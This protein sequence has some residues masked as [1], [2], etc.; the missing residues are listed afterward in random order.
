LAAGCPVLFG[1]HTE[2]FPDLYAAMAE[3]GAARCVATA[4]LWTHVQRIANS[5]AQADGPHAS[6]QVAGLAFIA[7]QQGSA[8]RTLAQLATLPCWPVEPMPAIRVQREGPHA[9]WTYARTAEAL[10]HALDARAFDLTNHAQD[11]HNLATGSG[12]GQAHKVQHDGHTWVLRHYRRGGWVARW[13]HDTYPSGPTVDTRAM[14]ELLLLRHMRSLGLPVPQPVAAHCQRHSKWLGR[15][16]RYR[17]NILIEHIPNTR[18][19]VQCLREGPLAPEA[20]QAIGRAVAQLHNKQIFHSDLNAHNILMN[21]TG[22]V[23][24]VD[25]DKCGLRPGDNWKATNLARLKRSLMKEQGRQVLHLNIETEW[26][27][28]LKGYE[29]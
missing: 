21:D 15:H 27:E 14:Q 11:A 17:A 22:H 19:V 13:V 8:A 3:C 24:L 6:M 18:N 28:L 5:Q 25:F 29:G 10:G 20:W 1:P 4:D 23:W 7:T 26:T 9:V 16:S 12:R 2:Q